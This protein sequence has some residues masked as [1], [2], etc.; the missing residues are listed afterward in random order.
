V[1]EVGLYAVEDAVQ[2]LMALPAEAMGLCDRGRIAAG[3]IADLVVFD[4]A[5]GMDLPTPARHP[6]RIEHVLVARVAV[7]S[8]GG[9]ADHRPGGAVGAQ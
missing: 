6:G 9:I 3:M 4:P 5:R 8:E 1:R 2:K 7:L